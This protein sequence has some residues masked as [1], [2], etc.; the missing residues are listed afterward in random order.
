M[1][2]G[3]ADGQSNARDAVRPVVQ[4]GGPDMTLDG[5]TPDP[6]MNAQD[7]TILVDV[8]P[9]GDV[10]PSAD[11]DLE[12]DANS[13]GPAPI[14]SE[15]GVSTIHDG[16]CLAEIFASPSVSDSYRD[17]VQTAYETACSF[18]GDV[19]PLE[20]WVTA[21]IESEA[22]ALRDRWC[23][24]RIERD[25]QFR[26]SWCDR[27]QLGVG[28]A[29]YVHWADV[30]YPG[31]SRE[32][33]QLNLSMFSNSPN[34]LS[35]EYVTMHEFFHSY[36]LSHLDQAVYSTHQSR[37]INLGRTTDSSRPWHTEGSANFISWQ[38]TEDVFQ[39]GFLRR[40]MTNI[41]SRCDDRVQAGFDVTTL[42][43]E[44]E[45][46]YDLGTW[47]MGYLISEHSLHEYLAFYDDINP[48]GFHGAFEQR[49]GL[50]IEAFSQT[51]TAWFLSTPRQEK[52]QRFGPSQ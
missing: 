7:M 25:V 3:C 10:N 46:A 37:D 20:I 27:S 5:A 4:D 47:A 52:L 1:L 12:Y 32:H 40:E 33:H 17:R 28:L 50:T 39:P 18:L 30:Y 34:D 13:P 29:N 22:E 44:D 41:L 38:L 36:Q 15:N 43:Y 26:A 23:Q 14:S 16:S 48:L 2:G 24:R 9:S 31:L 6:D 21:N 51:F 19:R 49:F 45:C 42:T 35:A 8:G 11:G